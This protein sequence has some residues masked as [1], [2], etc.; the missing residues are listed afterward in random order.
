MD[1]KYALSPS[2]HLPFRPIHYLGSKLRILDAVIGSIR[3]AAPKGRAVDLFSGSGTVAHSL[4]RERPVIAVDIQE[5]ARVLA[6]ALFIGGAAG[7]T[8]PSRDQLLRSSP[9][10]QVVLDCIKPLIKYEASL[11]QAAATGS[12]ERL[13]DFLAECPLLTLP[14]QGVRTPASVEVLHDTVRRLR[15][16]DLWGAP[17]TLALRHFGGVYFSF[18]QAFEIDL[19]LN[20]A[21]RKSGS[22]RDVAVGAVLSSASHAVSS[23]GKQ[24]AQPISLRTRA[25]QYKPHVVEKLLQERNKSVHAHFAAAVERFN[26]SE[27]RPTSRAERADYREFLAR[28]DEEYSVIY[29]DP[30]YTRDHYSRYYH[31][32]ETLALRDEP[33]ITQS[34]LGDARPSRGVYRA[35]R[36]QSP[37]SIRSQAPDAFR[38]LF[39]LARRHDCPLVLSYSPF[40]KAAGSHPRTIDLSTLADLAHG[41]FASVRIVSAGAFR[42]SKLNSRSRA[43]RASSEAEQIFICSP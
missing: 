22:A 41:Q 18:A 23:I 20:F 36:H 9:E 43:L 34:N 31:V 19:L 26:A 33:M 38:Q 6:N 3:D 12:F 25:G 11:E 8:T 17:Q 27:G 13:A 40:D 5:Y 21:H 14:A 15:E 39:A 28:R 4:S 24:F 29:A 30:P 10:L 42:H 1:R 2:E 35:N 7:L 16:A 32:L 37:F